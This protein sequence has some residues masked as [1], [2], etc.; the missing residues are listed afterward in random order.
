[1]NRSFLIIT[2]SFVVFVVVRFIFEKSEVLNRIDGQTP[3][4]FRVP[5]IF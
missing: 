3:R 2:Q 4:M 5:Y 1:M